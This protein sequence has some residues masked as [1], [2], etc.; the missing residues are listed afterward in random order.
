MLSENERQSQF[1]TSLNASPNEAADTLASIH[2]LERDAK[3]GPNPLFDFKMHPRR[4]VFWSFAWFATHLLLMVYMKDRWEGTLNLPSW[5]FLVVI[6]L[7]LAMWTAHIRSS[8][9]SRKTLIKAPTW[10]NPASGRH[11][12]IAIVTLLVGSSLHG[13]IMSLLP[14]SVRTRRISRSMGA[15][16]PTTDVGLSGHDY[17]LA[18]HQFRLSQS[19]LHGLGCYRSTEQLIPMSETSTPPAAVQPISGPYPC[20]PKTNGSHSP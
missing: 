13:L 17:V 14:D 4:A 7:L 11:L 12:A 20:S 18:C 9:Q 16:H 5:T 1:M 3:F 8:T 15:I 2:G 10:Y 6:G 19:S